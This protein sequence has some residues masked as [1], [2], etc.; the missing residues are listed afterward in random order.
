MGSLPERLPLDPSVAIQP[1]D[2]KRVAELSNAIGSLGATW[3]PS[4]DATRNQLLKQAR[5]LVLSLETPRETMI[6]HVWAQVS[7]FLPN[8]TAFG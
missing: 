5:A 8:L 7:L 3:S 6:R 4:D 2:A 1:N